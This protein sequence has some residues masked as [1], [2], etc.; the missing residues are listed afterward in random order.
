[1]D[2]PI[3]A[4]STPHSRKLTFASGL[5]ACFSCANLHD[6][7]DSDS[8]TP[9]PLVSHLG[10]RLRLTPLESLAR[11]ALDQAILRPAVRTI[12]DAYEEFLGLLDNEP[13][14]Q[15]LESL[16]PADAA[17]DATYQAARELS[18]RFQSGLDEFFLGEKSPLRGM[19]LKYGVF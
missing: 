10:D 14:R 4:T 3:P 9:Q 15:H 8:A 13:K 6:E 17:T 12:F 19:T 11:E 1:M 18:H 2:R 16:A 7:S 5:I